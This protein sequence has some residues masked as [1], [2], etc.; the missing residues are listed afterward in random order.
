MATERKRKARNNHTVAE[1]FPINDAASAQKYCDEALTSTAGE[2]SVAMFNGSG[3]VSPQIL[4]SQ[5][6]DNLTR[7]AASII[8]NI[9]NRI[10][11]EDNAEAVK[12]LSI[13]TNYATNAAEMQKKAR[14]E[15]ILRQAEEIRK[16]QATA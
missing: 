3:F 9:A 6:T 11:G 2:K 14:N 12:A 10:G 7:M 1:D 13:I 8:N 16:A 4:D 5:D 15:R